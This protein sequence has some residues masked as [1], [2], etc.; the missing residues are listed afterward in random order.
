MRIKHFLTIVVGLFLLAGCGEDVQEGIVGEYQS[1]EAEIPEDSGNLDLTWSITQQPDASK[2]TVDDLEFS[3]GDQKMTFIPDFPGTFVFKVVVADEFGDEIS[4]QEF[5][6]AA[7]AA[8][9]GATDREEIIKTED[10]IE[11]TVED[12]YVAAVKPLP[13]AAKVT[14]PQPV[15]SV[16]KT[17]RVTPKKPARPV[18]GATIP[19]DPY[20]YTIQVSAKRTFEDAQMAAE[21][22]IDAGFD[23]YIQKA[24]FKE[25]SETWYRVRVG[26]FES[27]SAALAVAKNIKSITKT[28]TWVDHVRL[29]N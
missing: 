22:L 21:K 25:T 23:S 11:D 3:A 10:T 13:T 9:D 1:V 26:S 24:Y 6:I 27:Y 5:T 17:T 4:V 2:I 29:E 15:K 16:P 28:D 20:R 7:L 12:S 14:T 8:T 19:K 18:P